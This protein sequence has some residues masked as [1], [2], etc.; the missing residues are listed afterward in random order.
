MAKKT[1]KRH[2]AGVSYKE[3]QKNKRLDSEEWDDE[4]VDPGKEPDEDT[5]REEPAEDYD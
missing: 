3:S 4:P 2:G 1:H 5:D